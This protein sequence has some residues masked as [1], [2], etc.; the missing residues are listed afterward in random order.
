VKAIEQRAQAIK[1]QCENVGGK[2]THTKEQR[3]VLDFVERH[4][5]VHLVP[6][7]GMVHLFADGASATGFRKQT[8]DQI[9]AEKAKRRADKD[10]QSLVALGDAA[11]TN[12]ALWDEFEELI[13]ADK[14]KGK[15]VR[16]EATPRYG[17]RLKN[18]HL[19]NLPELLSFTEAGTALGLGQT[20]IK[21]T[22]K[23]GQLLTK[24]IGNR[25]R[26]T[27]ASLLAFVHER[28]KPNVRQRTPSENRMFKFENKEDREARRVYRCATDFM[29]GIRAADLNL[30]PKRVVAAVPAPEPERPQSNATTPCQP[31]CQ[32]VRHGC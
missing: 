32:C 17:R 28:N 25:K 31:G 22:V 29:A 8:K 18:L 9:E 3:S 11:V 23:A 27:K 19:D 7:G 21:V 10:F 15:R 16:R 4:G 24:G 20:S 13:E 6:T 30:K 1:A 5:T 12:R 2:K 26:I 14:R